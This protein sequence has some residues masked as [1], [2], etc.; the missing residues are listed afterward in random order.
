MDNFNVTTEILT[1][2]EARRRLPEVRQ[3]VTTIITITGELQQAHE[4]LAARR[5]TGDDPAAMRRIETRLHAL[6]ASLK[7]EI[8]AVNVLGGY[9]K[10][11]A[12]GLLDFYCWRGDELVFLCW[13]SGEPDIRFWHGL[14]EGFVYRK[15]W[16][17]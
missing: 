10:D 6:E 14:D 8:R 1:I 5:S 16:E 3:R 7:D 11:A 17:V 13:R 2:E 12:T 4:D 9:L 15:P